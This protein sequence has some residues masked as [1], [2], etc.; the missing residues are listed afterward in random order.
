M[1]K[2]LLATLLSLALSAKLY[3]A[4][5]NEGWLTDFEAAKKAVAEKKMPILADF[6][7]SD[8]CGW[9]IKLKKEVFSQKE[10]KDFAKE[11][12]VLFM[13]DFPRKSKQDEKT[14][15]QNKELMTKYAVRGLPTVLL[16]DAEGKVLARTGYK[17]GGA[18][19]YIEHLKKM[20]ADSGKK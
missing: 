15:K 6:S 17:P 10:F 18:V 7:G 12:L 11:N 16:V 9:C 19:S 2:I 8:W 14:M 5:A 20:I 3:S 1:Q 4:E 13:A